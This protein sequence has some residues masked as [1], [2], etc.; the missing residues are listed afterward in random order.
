MT[1]RTTTIGL[2]AGLAM[3]A[4]APLA[5]AG[6]DLQKALA[7]GAERLAAE[8]I[9]ELLVGNTVKARAGDKEFLF[10]Y[11]T[12]NVISGKLIGGD[13][14]DQG[15]YGI[16]DTDQVCLSISQDEG[17]LRCIA[18]LRHGD[19]AVRKYDAEGAMTFELLEI[20][21]GNML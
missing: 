4:G 17:R 8:E 2:L 6:S 11:S 10:H 9:A 21:A 14:S 13:W 19:G 16:A 5:Q 12:D 7:E 15:Y 18:P 20:E 3:I 1:C